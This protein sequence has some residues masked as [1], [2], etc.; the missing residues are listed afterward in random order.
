MN[1]DFIRCKYERLCQQIP[2]TGTY[3]GQSLGFKTNVWT[4][5]KTFQNVQE[6]GSTLLIEFHKLVKKIKGKLNTISGKVKK[7]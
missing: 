1:F 5:Q 2:F 3:T 4:A 6:C 7:C